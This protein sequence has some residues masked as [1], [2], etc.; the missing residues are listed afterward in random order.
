M[1][2]PRQLL[3]R[4]I[5]DEVKRRL[6]W[7]L[8]CAALCLIGAV[9]LV[10][11]FG[12]DYARRLVASK[13]AEAAS[14][15]V[16]AEITNKLVSI[17]GQ[18]KARAQEIENHYSATVSNTASLDK[19]LGQIELD[20]TN[21]KLKFENTLSNYHFQ[22]V[23][24]GEEYLAAISKIRSKDNLFAITDLLSLICVQPVTNYI[25]WK[26]DLARQRPISRGIDNSIYLVPLDYEPIA[27]EVQVRLVLS[28]TN[29]LTVRELPLRPFSQY[30]YIIG[31]NAYITNA[32][33]IH[34]ANKATRVTLEYLKKPHFKPTP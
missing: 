30:G 17:E 8:G 24:N 32:L 18:A 5:E 9:T 26:P 22:V 13:V 33:N 11:F 7:W 10:G 6:L 25:D 4:Y 23:T 20:L 1:D 31:T 28:I 12:D 19:K 21:Y 2:D 29:E 27:N 3:D 16:I 15:T 14:P 34:I